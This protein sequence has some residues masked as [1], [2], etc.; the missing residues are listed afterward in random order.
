M[1]SEVDNLYARYRSELKPLV[2][3]YES[4][5]EQIMP[6]CLVNLAQMF[7]RIALSETSKTEEERIEHLNVASG[8]L[9]TAISDTKAGV[10][11]DRILKVLK[12][13]R[14]YGQD[15]INTLKEG[16]FVGPFTVLENEVGQ[17]IAADD[18]AA[19]SKLGAMVDMI[20]D[21]HASALAVSTIR[22]SRKTTFLK[23]GF[24]IIV[25][26]LVT[27]LTAWLF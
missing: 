11:A 14:T 20:N 19:L 8:H 15:I 6:S 16:A 1:A 5:N 9:N 22:D 17:S 26:L 18:G 27:L 10:V 25:S 3:E 23:W 2:A 4:Q 24:T 7:D 13:K 12:F 21:S